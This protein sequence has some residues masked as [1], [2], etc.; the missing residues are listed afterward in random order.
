M[1]EI[2]ETDPRLALAQLGDFLQ[3]KAWIALRLFGLW[4]VFSRSL[5]L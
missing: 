1:M 2:Q 5:C 3:E 4:L